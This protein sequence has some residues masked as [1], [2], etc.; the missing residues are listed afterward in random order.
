ML[1]PFCKEENKVLKTADHLICYK[2]K[3]SVYI[4]KDKRRRPQNTLNPFSGQ[5]H[6]NNPFRYN[7]YIEP[8]SLNYPNVYI[9]NPYVPYQMHIPNIPYNSYNPYTPYAPYAPNYFP[10]YPHVQRQPLYNKQALDVFAYSKAKYEVYKTALERDYKD[11][12][13]TLT[14]K[15]KN[16]NNSLDDEISK[17]KSRTPVQLRGNLPE[18]YQSHPILDRSVRSIKGDAIYKTMFN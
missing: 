16:L 11:K 3:N 8:K 9:T 5:V 14:S 18:K 6:E 12:N 10:A 4:Q 1:C 2:C 17:Y 7:N 13:D 15:I